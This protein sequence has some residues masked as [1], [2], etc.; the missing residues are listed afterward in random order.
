[1]VKKQIRPAHVEAT[2]ERGM[3]FSF[4]TP[5]R[6]LALICLVNACWAF[7]YGVEAPIASLWLRDHGLTDTLIGLNAA[8]YY[9]GMLLA[10][11]LVPWLMK[12]SARTC[13]GAGLIASGLAVSL[14][15][16][17]G[18]LAGWFVLRS[19][20]GVGGALSLVPMETL[21]NQN[22]PDGRRGRDFGCYA[23]AIA[24]GLALGA[25]VGLQLYAQLGELTFVV[26]GVVSASAGAIAWLGLRWPEVAEAIGGSFSLDWRRHLFSFGTSWSQGFLEGS[27]TA[28]LPLYLLAIGYSEAAVGAL[29]GGTMLGVILFQV[30]AGWLADHISPSR[31]LIAGYLL[32][33]AGL[34][35][36]PLCSSPLALAAL[37]F[38]VGACIGAFYPLGLARI[39]NGMEKAALPQA[40]AWYLAINCVGS[41]TGP[42]VAGI[43]SDFWGKTALFTTGVAAI[44]CVFAAW[45]AER[46][47]FAH[48]PSRC[49]P[50][51]GALPGPDDC[52]AA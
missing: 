1:L 38:G 25:W 17:G 13:A 4:R 2:D 35:V 34:S 16:W 7:S 40:N 29:I 36:L 42:A 46:R 26:G 33:A 39:G 43:A 21:V 52:Q 51:S 11:G 9:V 44:A 23:L 49:L 50:Q 28:F 3:G 41:L 15:P 31:V 47:Y 10:A 32:V 12:R 6:T 30:P 19:L 14:F 37:L 8:V 45:L 27:L 22:S 48:S 20:T 5:G 24:L 18:G